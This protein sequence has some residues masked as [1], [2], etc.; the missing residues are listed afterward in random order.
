VRLLL[1]RIALYLFHIGF[2]RPVLRWVVGVRYRR[3]AL[4][5]KGPCIVVSN[6]NSH[7]DA[8]VLMS[9]FPLGRIPRVHPVAAADYFG[10]AWLKRTMAMILMNGIPIERR[11]SGGNDPLARAVDEL[12]AGHSLVFFPE[13]SR[14]EAGVVAPFRPGV[15]R[16]VKSVPGLPVVPVFLAGPERIW[17]RGQVVPVPLNI[18]AIVGKPRTFAADLD[19]RDIAEQVQRDVLSLAP[20]PPPVPGP[21]PQP[22]LRVAVCGLHDPSREALFR[23]IT[24]RLGRV[25][26]V[27][28]ISDPVLEADAEGLREGSA[29]IPFAPRRAWLGLLARLFRTGGMFKGQRFAE[30]VDRAQINEALD[31]AAATRFVVTDGNAL[32]DLLAWAEADF[33]EGVFDEAGLNHLL[34]YLAHHKRIPFAHWWRFIRKAPEVWLVNILELAQPPVPDLVVLATHPP[35]RLMESLRARGEELRPFENESFLGKLQEAYSHVGKVLA[36]RHRVE[37]LEVDLSREDVD[38]VAARIESISRKRTD[39][40]A[41][42]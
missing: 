36:K 1:S 2:V 42:S 12:E 26:Q 4:V 32:V 38:S 9:L 40:P 34:E 7:L 28:G 41:S 27:L 8:A 17:P 39:L 22:P 16:L 21:P 19:P 29:P 23:S 31:R 11:A 18:D 25:G 30:M 10:T 24:E 37:C 33:Y 35:A 6:H 20:P 5:P 15:G 13:G 3:R 14:G